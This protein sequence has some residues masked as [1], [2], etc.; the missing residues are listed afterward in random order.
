MKP[1]S[2]YGFEI[3]AGKNM[4]TEKQKKNLKKFIYSREQ[5]QGGFSFSPT[6]PPTLEDTYFALRLFE[7][8]QEYS[9]SIQTKSYISQ[10][11]HGEFHQSKHLYHLATMYRILHLTDALNSLRDTIIHDHEFGINTLS[12][13]Y[14]MAL[15]KEL[16]HMPIML[17]RNEQAVLSSAQLKSVK[18][19]EECKQLIILLVKLHK[20]FHHQAY[21]H[22]IQSTQN[23]DGGFGIVHHSTSFLDPTYQALRGLKELHACPIDIYKCERFVFSCMTNIGCFGRQITTIP[24]LEYSYYGFLSLKMI[25][26]MKNQRT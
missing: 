19:M 10:F 25:D 15:T 9:I 13:L 26:E 1:F 7:E 4:L 3:V 2:S 8:L 22:C 23:F 14:Y 18:S 24:A 20:P 16:L 11:N 6:T 17:T 12:D 21:I 5:P